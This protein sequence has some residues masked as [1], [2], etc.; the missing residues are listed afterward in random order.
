MNVTLSMPTVLVVSALLLGACAPG[1]EPTPTPP[2]EA[3]TDPGRVSVSAIVDDDVV[4]V[5]ATAP[6][7]ADQ[8]VMAHR[9]EV[10][11]QGD[12]PVTLDDARL[13]LHASGDPHGDLV[14][15]GR[16]CGAQWDDQ[17]GELLQPCTSDLEIIELAPGETH[18]YPATIHPEVGPLRLLPGTYE[19]VERIGWESAGER[20]EF[21]ATLTYVVE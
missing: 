9:V 20:G 6:E 15:S 8:G 16:G 2:D 12:A 19:V 17:R 4:V 1:K 7:I 3:V 10:T 14:V 21:S 5:E 13:T 11:W 18:P